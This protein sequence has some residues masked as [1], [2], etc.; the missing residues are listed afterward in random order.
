MPDYIVDLLKEIAPL[1]A[2]FV[3][4]T[5]LPALI[6]RWSV[7]RLRRK[8]DSVEKSET[9]K[10]LLSEIKGLKEEVRE[11]KNEILILRGKRK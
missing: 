10:E 5:L 11:L 6:S 3:T 9:D 4:S 2:G 8:I 7:S 1:L